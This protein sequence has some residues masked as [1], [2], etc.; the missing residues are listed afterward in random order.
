MPEMPIGR[1]E[2]FGP[3]AGLARA[4]SLEAALEMLAKSPV[5]QRGVDL[6]PIRA[7]PRGSSATA[8]GSR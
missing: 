7:G 5:R 6:H 4:P 1:E 2:V 8:R 3:V